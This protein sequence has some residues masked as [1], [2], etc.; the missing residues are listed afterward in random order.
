MHSTAILIFANSVK[1][2]LRNKPVP[3]GQ[4]LFGSL[5]DRALKEVKKTGLPYFHLTEKEQKGSS[6]GMRF[7]HAINHIFEQGF[8]KVIV[9]GNDTPQL[10]S[11]HLLTAAHALQKGHDVL[12][13][14]LDG[15]FYLLGIHKRN[16]R[17]DS[18]SQLP[19]QTARVLNALIQY[20]GTSSK[21]MIRLVALGDVDNLADIRR[22]CNFITSI[23]FRL[24]VLLRSLLQ[25]TQ[26]AIQSSL[27]LYGSEFLTLQFNKGSPV[28][29]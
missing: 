1:E 2:D 23:P 26:K 15:G 8:E 13:P 18:L 12:G 4:L 10:C 25:T 28:S 6:F 24:L 11:N 5:T 14:S 22:L 7:C 16:F 21:T 9:I 17:T 29:A 3:K 19:W 20:L 27:V